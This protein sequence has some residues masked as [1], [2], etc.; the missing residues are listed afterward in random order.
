MQQ[1]GII[2]ATVTNSGFLTALYVVLT[3]V[4]ALIFF[5]TPVKTLVWVAVALAFIGTWLLSGGT[6]GG[7]TFGDGLVA[8]SAVFWAAHLLAVER[9]S[10]FERPLLFTAGHFVVVFIIAGVGAVLFEPISWAKIWAAMPAILFVGVLSTAATFTLMAIA[11][12]HTPASEAAI[13]V[14]M[15]TVFAAIAAFF[16][17]DERL[18]PIGWL[19]AALMM[20][21]TF[22]VHAMPYLKPKNRGESG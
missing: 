12:K 22:T 2:T 20:A 8:M 9:S 7:F 5:R 13:L 6:I 15:E 1:A 21:A 17:R 16:I 4:L 19:G 14:S 10:P 18:A 3:P 11:M